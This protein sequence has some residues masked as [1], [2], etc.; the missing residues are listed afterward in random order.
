M[1]RTLVHD[2]LDLVSR[3]VLTSP[4][5]GYQKGTWLDDLI[6][7]ALDAFSGEFTLHKCKGPEV[8][9]VVVLGWTSPTHDEPSVVAAR[10]SSM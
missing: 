3:P 10:S 1:R 7:Q 6:E 2:F 8:E 9:K 5:A 4:S